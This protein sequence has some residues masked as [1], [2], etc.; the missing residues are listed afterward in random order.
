MEIGKYFG[1]DY[2]KKYTTNE[3][4]NILLKY[5]NLDIKKYRV[6]GSFFELLRDLSKHDIDLIINF[7]NMF[8]DVNGME[9][10]NHTVG[11]ICYSVSGIVMLILSYIHTHDETHIYKITD[12]LLKNSADM[13]KLRVFEHNGGEKKVVFTHFISI[14]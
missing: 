12:F 9:A 2:K 8:K 7:I 3:F 13:S 4:N 5:N 10:V 1:I 11:Y 6:D 14:I